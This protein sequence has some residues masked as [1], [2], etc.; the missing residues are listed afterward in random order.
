MIAQSAGLDGR[1]SSYRF[2][3]S[4]SGPSRRHAVLGRAVS[5]STWEATSCFQS[6]YRRRR[7]LFFQL[8][9]PQQVFTVVFCVH[10]KAFLQVCARLTGECRVLDGGSTVGWWEM[11]VV[12]H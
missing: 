1:N 3:K 12:Q 11:F 7:F 8:V 4:G 5:V 2:L 9:E 10:F 6:G